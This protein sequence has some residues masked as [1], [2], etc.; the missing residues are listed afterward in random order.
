MP[1]DIATE[2]WVSIGSGDGL[3]NVAQQCQAITWTNVDLL[4]VVRS[5]GIHLWAI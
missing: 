4:H 1:Y 2:I 3:F 5:S